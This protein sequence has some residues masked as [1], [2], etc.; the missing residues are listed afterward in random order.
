VNAEGLIA[1]GDVVLF[2]AVGA[3]WT[4]GAAVYRWD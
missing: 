4:W 3:G 2:A 1:P